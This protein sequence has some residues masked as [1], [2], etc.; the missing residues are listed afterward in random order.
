MTAALLP[1][2]HNEC[3]VIRISRRWLIKELATKTGLVALGICT[4][5][6]PL[7]IFLGPD[8]D[9]SIAWAKNVFI[10]YLCAVGGL[11]FTAI[12]GKNL[13]IMVKRLPQIAGERLLI[14]DSGIQLIDGFGKVFGNVPYDN[15]EDIE[16]YGDKAERLGINLRDRDDANTLWPFDSKGFKAATEVDAEFSL[17]F[18]ERY[19]E[20]PKIINQKLRQRYDTYLQRGGQK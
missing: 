15:F 19:V 2:I 8:F 6:V 5:S 4:L 18:G 9:N 1:M 13:I 10:G 11:I 12:S 20:P 17:T 3:E 14:G 16:L 7:V